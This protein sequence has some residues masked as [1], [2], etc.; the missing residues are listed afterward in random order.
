M[1]AKDRILLVDDETDFTEALSKRMSARGLVVETAENGRVALD[2]AC[3]DKD[4]TAIVLDLKMPGMDGIETLKRLRECNP[5]LQ[6]ILLTGHGSIPE[7]VKAMKLG[8]LDFLEKP[9]D[10]QELMKKIEAAKANK[11]VL[12]EKHMEEDMAKILGTKA[13]D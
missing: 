6:I 10:F 2:K 11:M 3:Q 7:T 13:W 12:V 4:F 5:D 8:A 9:A 1:A